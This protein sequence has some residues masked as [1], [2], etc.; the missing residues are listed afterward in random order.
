MRH[1]GDDAY[2]VV[3]ADKGTAKFSDVA[4]AISAQYGFWLGD[5]FASGG[6]AGYDHKDM[7]ITARGG[8]ESV[9]R[10]FRE[11]GRDTQTQHFT[12]AGIG[13]MSGDVFG[14]AMLLSPHIRLVAAFDHRHIFLDPAPEGAHSFAER[15]RLFG[16]ATSSWEDYDKRLLSKGGAIHSR[17]SKSIPLS[18]EARGLL[19]IDASAA[20]PNEVIRAI[21]R[22]PVDLLWN[23][24][25]GTYVKATD[26]T[27]AEIGDRANDSV[28]VNGAELRCRVVGEGGNLGFS[29]RGRIEYAAAGGRI[30]TDFIDNSAG[31]NCRTSR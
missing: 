30:N 15:K 5:A 10:H 29:Q 2:L 14:N 13:D 8:W 7:A 27:H 25:I 16:L 4:N 24:G 23:G 1:D 26:E 18:A 20:P 9:R 21:L 31:V 3:A 17:Q 19:G 28:R 11:F 6:S 22:M 12:A